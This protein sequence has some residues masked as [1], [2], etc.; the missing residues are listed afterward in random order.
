MF[1]PLTDLW[2]ALHEGIRL[3]TFFQNPLIN[4]GPSRNALEGC[5]NAVWDS[6][7]VLQSSAPAHKHV[8]QLIKVFEIKSRQVFWSWLKLLS[9]GQQP[10][11]SGV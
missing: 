3:F 1:P 11:S 5:K 4:G 2:K 10:Y 6:P 9:A 7:T 8:N